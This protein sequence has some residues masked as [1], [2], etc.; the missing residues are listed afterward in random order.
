MNLEKKGEKIKVS[1][2]S[3]QGHWRLMTFTTERLAG[4]PRWQGT[5]KL[6]EELLRLEASLSQERQH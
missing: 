1:F 4:T 6:A 2:A 5:E 3:Y